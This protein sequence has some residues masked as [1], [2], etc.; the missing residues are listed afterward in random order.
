MFAC[1]EFCE[2]R[3]Y[4]VL[5]SWLSAGPMRKCSYVRG[6]GSWL[7]SYIRTRKYPTEDRRPLDPRP[8]GPGRS[9]QVIM[10]GTLAVL[11]VDAA[12]TP[13]AAGET[14]LRCLGRIGRPNLT[15]MAR[16]PILARD[17]R[18][19]GLL[20]GGSAGPMAIEARGPE[21]CQVHRFC[22]SLGDPLRQAP[23]YR[24]AGLE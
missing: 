16:A 9:G 20:T 11:S 3:L 2:P 1:D 8:A 19:C 23:A 21:R 10:D 6:R 22:L 17:R 4:R 13:S 15:G 7:C 12:N 14:S 24:R 5:R 18:S